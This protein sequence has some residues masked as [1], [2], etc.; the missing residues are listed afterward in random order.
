MVPECLGNAPDHCCYVNGKVC[1][2]LEEGTVVGRRWACGLLV[3]YGS[4]AKMSD[5]VE[6]RPIGEHWVSISSPFNYCETFHTAFCCRPEFRLGR[7][8]ET[9]EPVIDLIGVN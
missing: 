6:Y 5:S 2:Y 1:A 7:S 3:K 8:N 9:S 4:W